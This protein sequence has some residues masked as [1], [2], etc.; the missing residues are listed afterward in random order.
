[1]YLDT[2]VLVALFTNDPLNARAE[3]VLRAVSPEIVVSDFAAAEFASAI[4]RRV[5]VKELTSAEAKAVFGSFDAWMAAETT[6]VRIMSGD[7][8]SATLLM[9]RL[10]LP[11]RTGDA[12]NIA[13]AQRVQ[14]DL[15]TFDHQMLSSARILG[16]RH[17]SD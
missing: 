10:D 17:L 13:I 4:A 1:V 14:A 2:S 3:T 8:E 6:R 12:V 7:I 15:M 11:L 9:R 16:M 5:R